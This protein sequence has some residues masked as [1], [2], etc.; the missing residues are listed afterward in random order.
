MYGPDGGVFV[1]DWCDT[2]ECHNYQNITE[3]TGRI[4]KVT[5]GKPAAVEVDLAKLSDEELVKLQLHKN[6]WWVR[7]ARRLLQERAKD[8]K[9]DREKVLP[10]LVKMLRE[11]KE[12]P[13]RLRALWALHVIGGLDEK[14]L[15]RLL[16]DADETVRGWAVRL[17]VEDRNPSAA[18]TTKFADMA[19]KDK[20]ASVR[21]A[22]A[23]A[24][25]RMRAEGAWAVAEGL[26]SHEEDANDANLPLMI[27][28]GIEPLVP[29]NPDRAAVFLT[30]GRIPLV[31]EYIARR[32][33]AAADA[34]AGPPH[35]LKPLVDIL[36]R[37]TTRPSSATCF[38]E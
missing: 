29:A 33:A 5:Y 34:P 21:L 18:A 9:L 38:R 19:H 25:Q 32:I 20:S 26:A 14:A 22:L 23:S 8:G 11:E 28:Y 30:K 7:H 24:L 3:T 35:T 37:P 36:R 12:T 2:G 15:T 16:D 4:Y 31:R 6:D 13:L 1:S 10:P 27:W 17:L